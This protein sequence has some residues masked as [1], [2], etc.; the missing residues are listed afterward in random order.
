VCRAMEHI[1]PHLRPAVVDAAGAGSLGRRSRR[2]AALQVALLP[3]TTRLDPWCGCGGAAISSAK[4]AVVVFPSPYAPLDS[5]EPINDMATLVILP[6]SGAI[7]KVL[8]EAFTSLFP[9]SDCFLDR[10]VR[11]NKQLRTL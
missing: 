5:V 2:L 11:P 3:V 10:L 9:E 7:P 8:E 6:S 4:E 1:C